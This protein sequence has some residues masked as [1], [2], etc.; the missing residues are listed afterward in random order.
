[1]FTLLLENKAKTVIISIAL[2]IVNVATDAQS[3][4]GF[5]H[6]SKQRQEIIRAGKSGESYD[7]LIQINE[8]K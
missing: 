4:F 3:H 1:M 2:F 6:Y 7:Y 5:P 8:Y